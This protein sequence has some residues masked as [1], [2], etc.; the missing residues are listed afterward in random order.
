MSK[1]LIFVVLLVGVAGFV[2]YDQAP[3][4]KIT[5]ETPVTSG[6]EPTEPVELTPSVPASKTLD[7]SGQGLKQVPA[8]VFTKTDIQ[9]LD[10]SDNQL[11]G[12]L[13]AEVRHLQKLKVLNLSN[14]QFT[15]VP[16]EIGQL[17]N[18]EVLDLSN[19]QLTGLPYELGNLTKLRVL[20]LRGNAYST[21]DLNI[22]KQSLPAATVVLVD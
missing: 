10:V 2:W 7:L 13:P 16:A 18:L 6:T 20:D 8:T 14:N 9:E 22:I 12:A 3:T 11:T 17:Q 1:I 21:T 5:E 19:N 15:G 4:E